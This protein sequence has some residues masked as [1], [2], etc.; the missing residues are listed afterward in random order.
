MTESE[1]VTESVCGHRK[2]Y[3]APRKFDVA[4]LLVITLAYAIFFG[5]MSQ[6]PFFAP[7]FI[8]YVAIFIGVICV[9]QAVLFQAK[10]PRLASVLTGL[11][12]FMFT[13]FAAPMFTPSSSRV[14]RYFLGST[15]FDTLIILFF[16]IVFGSCFGYL[17][18][19]V[20]GG[21]FLISEAARSKI[22]FL[23]PKTQ[24]PSNE[25][26]NPWTDDLI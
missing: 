20:V 9:A 1:S 3:S 13:L 4:T 18:G 19:A 6:V 8:A 25:N 24:G 21:V 10:K 5:G 7:W 11:T 12:M 22:P 17:A 16:A 26:D 23:R 14:V 2:V 15:I